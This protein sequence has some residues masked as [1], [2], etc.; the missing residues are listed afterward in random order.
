[1]TIG[2][3]LSKYGQKI[4]FSHTTAMQRATSSWNSVDFCGFAYKYDFL[5]V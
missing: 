3:H 4:G 2:W 1:M 5:L